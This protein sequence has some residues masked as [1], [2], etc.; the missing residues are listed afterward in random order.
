MGSEKGNGMAQSNRKVFFVA[1]AALGLAGLIVRRTSDIEGYMGPKKGHPW[2]I[3]L[4]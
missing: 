3:G 1:L 4:E 2:G